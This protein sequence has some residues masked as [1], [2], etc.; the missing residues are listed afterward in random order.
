MVQE[1]KS[2]M[3]S[4]EVCRLTG[5]VCFKLAQE[6]FEE[7]RFRRR[8]ELQ[9]EKAL[10]IAQGQ[11][12]KGLELRAAIDLSSYWQ[13]AGKHQRA[14]LLLEQTTS[15]FTEGFQTADFLKAREQLEVLK[16]PQAATRG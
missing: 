5:I 11:K 6:G 8:A 15:W 13:S 14:C 10:E 12:A 3:Y 7:E 16:Q 9:L 1:T 2:F 4:A